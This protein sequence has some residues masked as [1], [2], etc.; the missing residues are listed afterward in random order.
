MLPRL[1]FYLAI[2]RSIGPTLLQQAAITLTRLHAILNNY[3]HIVIGY[4]THIISVE[5][6]ALVSDWHSMKN[7]LS[8]IEEEKRSA[9]STLL[10][11]MMT[12]STL[13]SSMMTSS[14]LLSPVVT[15]LRLQLDYLA[16]STAAALRP[17]GPN[18][19]LENEDTVC[20]VILTGII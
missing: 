9:S 20:D 12:S 18:A 19:C 14:R 5:H 1:C 10:S 3:T 8:E 16:T 11:S 6:S 17:L 4:H 7:L 2:Y 13:L 15:S